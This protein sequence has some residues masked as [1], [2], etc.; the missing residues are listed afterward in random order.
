LEKERMSGMKNILC[1]GDSNTYGYMPGAGTRYPRE[2]RWTGRLQTL[3]GSG[4][5]VVEEGLNGRTTA[6]EDEIQPWRSG[7]RYVGC[8]VKSHAPLDLMLVML[9]TN[10]CKPR[11]C[12]SPAEIGF[13]LERLIQTTETFFRYQAD[14]A[15]PCP[16]FLIVSPVPM[17]RTGGDPEMDETSLEKQAALA[18]V[19]RGIAGKYGCAFADAGAWISPELL[20]ADGCHFLPEAHRIFAQSSSRNSICPARR[21]R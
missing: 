12:V 6:F 1:F 17:S 14:Q 11:Y 10:D 4:C 21:F 18:E 20:G 7:L 13:G 16:K 5:C 15:G 8:C 2:I 19:Y 3:L 9:G